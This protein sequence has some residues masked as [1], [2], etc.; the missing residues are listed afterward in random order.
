MTRLRSRHC[1]V[2]VQ[3][4]DAPMTVEMEM[5]DSLYNRDEGLRAWI[6]GRGFGQT[7][8][9]VCLASLSV[10][11]FVTESER[12]ESGM[13]ADIELLAEMNT[14]SVKLGVP[15]LG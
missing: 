10:R 7:R 2:T 4:A 14:W 15:A 5:M 8:Y 1:T 6:Y 13:P 11:R 12:L 9:Q 3:P